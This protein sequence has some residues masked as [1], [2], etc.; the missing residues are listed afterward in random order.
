MTDYKL[1]IDT[2]EGTLFD[3]RV[4]SVVFESEDGSVGILAKRSQG[5][6]ALVPGKIRIQSADGNLHRGAASSGVVVVEKERVHILADDMLWEEEIDVERQKKNLRLLKERLFRE[7]QMSHR[8]YV[9]AT[10]AVA[11]AQARLKLKGIEP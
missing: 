7:K 5:I 11:R 8:E 6:I 9:L 10:A 3:G 4:V 2:P 1:I